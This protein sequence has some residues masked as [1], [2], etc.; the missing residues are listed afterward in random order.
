MSVPYAM[1][2]YTKE[3]VCTKIP[4]GGLYMTDGI[5][6]KLDSF[7]YVG[8]YRKRKERE[9]RLKELRKYISVS[10]GIFNMY[11]YCDYPLLLNIGIASDIVVFQLALDSNEATE[12]WYGKEND[13]FI[14]LHNN[15]GRSIIYD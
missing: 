8:K 7:L 9:K 3:M 11:P 6:K 2:E 15:R 12:I 4:D 13:R 14:V 5:S 1:R 10:Y